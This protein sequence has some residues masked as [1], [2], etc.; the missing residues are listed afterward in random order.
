MNTSP[1][2]FIIGVWIGKV[3]GSEG[4]WGELEELKGVRKKRLLL[5]YKIC[6]TFRES[7]RR[8]M[9]GKIRSC[10][11][12]EDVWGGA[13]KAQYI[14]AQWQRLGYEKCTKSFAPCKGNIFILNYLYRLYRAL[15]WCVRH[16][17]G[18]CPT[19]KYVGLSALF[20]P[21]LLPICLNSIKNKV[22]RLVF[23]VNPLLLRLFKPPFRSPE[24]GR[25]APRLRSFVIGRDAINRVSTFAPSPLQPPFRSPEGGR[26]APRLRAF[27][28]S[29]LRASVLPCVPCASV[30]K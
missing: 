16:S 22:I 19:L 14:S 13:L 30:L 15:D 25:L 26:L 12:V 3:G 23:T 4:S 11:V 6:H 20:S 8:E 9:A 18:R 2:R 27:V 24:R 28:P 1:K 29:P 5:Q 10:L 21:L 17:V 7:N